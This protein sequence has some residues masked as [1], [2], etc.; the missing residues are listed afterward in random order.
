M[1]GRQPVDVIKGLRKPK[2]STT[3]FLTSVFTEIKEEVRAT[4]M[5]VK[6]NAVQKLFVV[7][8]T[9]LYLDG[10]EMEWAAF[11]VIELMSSPRVSQKRFGYLACEQCFGANPELLLL[12]TNLFRKDLS[13]ASHLDTTVALNTLSMVCTTDLAHSLADE[14]LSLLSNSKAIIRKKATALF[15]KIYYFMPEY[16]GQSLD[17]IAE[18]LRDE[19]PS[20]A[21]NAVNTL[22]EQARRTPQAVL[23]TAS[24]LYELLRT[25]RSNWMLIKLL[26]LVTSM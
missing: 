18:K 19:N 26:K 13:G 3:S 22:Y 10:Y 24:S 1:F 4:D 25:T 5:A 8:S 20:V 21:L 16:L 2:Q 17:R 12:T 14:C 6:C 23:Y 11:H 9:Q 7:S 15:C